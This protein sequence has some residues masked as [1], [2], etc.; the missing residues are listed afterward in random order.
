MSN[1]ML[2]E[3][4][5]SCFRSNRSNIPFYGWSN[6][7]PASDNDKICMYLLPELLLSLVGAKTLGIR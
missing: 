1:S 5:C 7:S 4:V 3:F 6:G 2:F